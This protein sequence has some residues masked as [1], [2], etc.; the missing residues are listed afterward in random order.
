MIDL[1]EEPVVDLTGAASDS[2]APNSVVSPRGTD[3]VQPPKQDLELIEKEKHALKLAELRAKTA[4][5]RG[6]DTVQPPKQDLELIEKEKR[7][8]KLAELKA[9]A[10]L[11]R[12]KLRIA[13]QKKARGNMA[14]VSV[15][16]SNNESASQLNNTRTASSPMAVSTS[17]LPTKLRPITIGSLVIDDVALTGPADE[18][19][20][21]S[22]VYR[23]SS[24]DDQHIQEED[25]VKDS[26][27]STTPTKVPA[28]KAGLS[29]EDNRKKSE[30]LKQ[31]L[32][33]ARLQLEILKKRKAL[34][35]NENNESKQPRLSNESWDKN[36]LK[37]QNKEGNGNDTLEQESDTSVLNEDNV[38]N[39][40]EETV[41][42]TPSYD[43]THAKLNQLRR[44]QKELKQKNDIANMRNLIHKQRDMLQAQ[45]GELTESST[46]LQSCVDGIQSKQTLL[47]ESERRLEEMNHRKRIVEGMVFRAT[48]QLIAARKTLCD[49]RRHQNNV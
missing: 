40:Q 19:R 37:E 23:H 10:K 25:Q 41:D 18:V 27:N 30:S 47:D 4:S 45:G 35:A 11:A 20:F 16:S 34:S 1:T 15:D 36:Q 38:V 6:T 22:S 33:L 7:A 31:Q 42:G 26:N 17:P 44:R 39:T 12:A 24:R 49:R 13:E 43:Q 48:E 9:R 8:L 29:S 28:Q 32:Q 14:R 3:T 21:V 2:D 46:Q 5:L